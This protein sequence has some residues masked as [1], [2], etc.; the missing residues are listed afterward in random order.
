MSKSLNAVASIQEEVK[1]VTA[2]FA[3]GS[4]EGDGL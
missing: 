2:N 3:G 4:E 1:C